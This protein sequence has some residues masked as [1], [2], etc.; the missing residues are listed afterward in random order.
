MSKPTKEDIEAAMEMFDD[1]P[2]G[3]FFQ[4]VADNIGVDDVSDVIE[5]MNE[6]GMT[7][8]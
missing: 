2:D 3:A 7:E 5:L 4:A 1:L 8:S 6:Y